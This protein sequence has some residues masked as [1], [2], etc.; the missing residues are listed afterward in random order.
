[1]SRKLIE[2]LHQEHLISQSLYHEAQNIFASGGD[3]IRDFI[4]RRAI[5]ESKI[6]YFLSQRFSLQ[7]INLSKF[8]VKLEIPAMINAGTARLTQAIPIQKNSGTLVVATVDP[9]LFDSLNKIRESTKM[10]VEPVLTTYAA[11]DEAFERF[12]G[13][14]ILDLPLG[15][16]VIQKKVEEESTATQIQN[17]IYPKNKKSAEVGSEPSLELGGLESVDSSTHAMV[18]AWILTLL[19]LAQKQGSG[20]LGVPHGALHL[21]PTAQGLQ[22]RLR[23]GDEIKNLQTA[24]PELKRAI[25]SHI[26][27]E[28]GM[29]IQRVGVPQEG[30]W[31][32]KVNGQNVDYKVLSLP[33]VQGEKI[34]IEPLAKIVA[35]PKIEELGLSLPQNKII[36][37]WLQ[38]RF[39]LLALSGSVGSGKSLTYYSILKQALGLEKL[40]L[41]IENKVACIISDGVQIDASLGAPFSFKEAVRMAAL[42]KPHFVFI[43]DFYSLHQMKELLPLLQNEISVLM[44]LPFSTVQQTQKKLFEAE[45]FNSFVQGL[46]HKKI[47]NRVEYEHWVGD[48][49]HA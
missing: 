48:Q 37:N 26:K 42:Q 11:F 35:E 49:D 44:S 33:S 6:L 43:R 27:T 23:L 25:V 9:T 4:S 2:L 34:F 29:D 20:L 19:S 7:S 32:R 15:A 30:K 45:M 24:A 3:A 14:R 1:M 47:A 21:E 5:S 10:D 13:V 46:H 36:Q 22:A 18:D 8:N 41:S 38:G 17:L 16:Q 12:Y 39:Q 31:S 28:C 40:T